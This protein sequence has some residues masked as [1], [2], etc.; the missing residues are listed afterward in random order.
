VTAVGPVR[1]PG[2]LREIPFEPI[3]E[4]A[5]RAIPVPVWLGAHPHL[6]F[7]GRGLRRLLR[8]ERWD[9]VHCWEEPYVVAAAQVAALLDNGVTFV[10]A[11]F[12]NIAKRYPAPAALLEARVLHRANGWIAFGQS[13]YDVQHARPLYAARPAR[14]INPGVDVDVFRPDG[15][16]RRA[17]R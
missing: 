2:D 17:V 15:A 11:T 5:S 4:D 10:P 1:L 14:V 9:V 3:V 12:Q 7:Y 8:H 13:V 6:R 16:A